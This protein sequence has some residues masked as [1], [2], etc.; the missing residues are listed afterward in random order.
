MNR[1]SRALSFIV[2]V[3]LGVCAGC[4]KGQPKTV[5]AATGAGS[6]T[7]VRNQLQGRWTL[8]S[9][10]VAP[11]GGQRTNIEAT[12][13][14]SFDNFG[15]LSIEYR[16]SDAGQKALEGLGIK[17]PGPV[18][19]TSGNVAIDPTQRQI[20]YMAEGAQ[21][22]AFAFDAD[23]A[24]RRANPFTVDRI[25]HYQFTDDGLLTLTTRYD[26]GADAAVARWKRGS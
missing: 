17:T 9:L 23:Q 15:N 5:P 20:R 25:R 19:S 12:G 22:K 16:L 1:R 2:A 26:S 7:D 6:I 10:D 14:M 21:E 4:A 11:V 8:M 24:A 3:T 18:L 13:V